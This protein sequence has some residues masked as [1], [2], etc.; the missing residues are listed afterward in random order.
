MGLN[1]FRFTGSISPHS[2]F[3]MTEGIPRFCRRRTTI[4]GSGP[5]PTLSP[6]ETAPSIRWRSRSRRTCRKASRLPCMSDRIAIRMAGKYSLFS[7]KSQTVNSDP[8]TKAGGSGKQDPFTHHH[9][10][11]SQPT[12]RPCYP[13]RSTLDN[14]RGTVIRHTLIPALQRRPRTFCPAFRHAETSNHSC[15]R[16]GRLYRNQFCAPRAGKAY[17]WRVVKSGHGNLCR[18]SRQ[19]P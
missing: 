19:F 8:S 15:D 9:H 6:S 4:S 17:R 13:R 1:Q 14:H 18:Q 7:Q 16:R 12:N 2:W 3:P 5:Y 11:L 10:G